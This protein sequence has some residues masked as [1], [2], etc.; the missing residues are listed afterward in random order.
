VTHKEVWDFSVGLGSGICI[1][2]VGNPTG[3]LLGSLCQML[4]KE[5]LA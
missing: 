4:N 1:S 3:T 2:S 5:Q